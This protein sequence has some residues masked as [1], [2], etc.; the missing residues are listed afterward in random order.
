MRIGSIC[1]G[2]ICKKAY[3][4]VLTTRPDIELVLCTR[5][6]ATID[7]MKAKYRINEGYTSVEE[8]IASGIDAAMVHSSTETHFSFCKK[9]LENK[10][11]V[12]VDKPIGYNYKDTEELYKLA[13]MNSTKIMVGFHTKMSIN[14]KKDE[15][16]LLNVIISPRVH[17]SLGLYLSTLF[18]CFH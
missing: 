13:Q 1:I 18:R 7:E 11:P 14:Y 10:I 6:Q 17:N 8:L 12:Y 15:R 4:P 9:L 2:D 16:G 5:N 3:L